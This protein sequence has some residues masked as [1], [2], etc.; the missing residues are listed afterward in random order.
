MIPPPEA[1]Q[2][3]INNIANKSEI[4]SVS[5]EQF[6]MSMFSQIGEPLVRA[7]MTQKSQ[8][9]DDSARRV[10][11]LLSASIRMALT[12]A[13]KIGVPQDDAKADD[14]RLALTAFASRLIGARFEKLQ[15]VPGDK[16]IEKL[17]GCVEAVFVVAENFAATDALDVAADLSVGNATPENLR[18]VGATL[19]V[20]RAVTAYSFG[21]TERKLAQ[22]IVSSIYKAAEALQEKIDG[23]KTLSPQ[24]VG[25]LCD[26]YAQCYNDEKGRLLA[27]PENQ[28][29]EA[30][31]PDANGNPAPLIDIWSRFELACDIVEALALLDSN[32]DASPATAPVSPPAPARPAQPE[33]QAPPPPETSNV[34]Q[35]PPARPAETQS[36]QAASGNPMAFFAKKEN[37][38]DTQTGAGGQS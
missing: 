25:A 7:V 29:I 32:G 35:P 20:I 11:A 23:Q 13:D 8:D 9:N 37:A 14:L 26:L 17:I 6:L 24:L 10:A 19:P 3:H 5:R 16:E 33:T 21:K 34:P 28:Q 31:K 15:S 36:D 12:T 22:D 1:N 4:M 30:L 38:D 27:L 2:L 18:Y